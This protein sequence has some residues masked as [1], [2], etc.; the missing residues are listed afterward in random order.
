MKGL[1][2]TDE[3]AIAPVLALK[4]HRSRVIGASATSCG[5]APPQAVA[6]AAF[7]RGESSRAT[8]NRSGE[9]RHRG[10]ERLRVERR[11]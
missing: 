3:V 7:G 5:K 6:V 11:V 2:V 4:P 8:R 1:F 10:R 9:H